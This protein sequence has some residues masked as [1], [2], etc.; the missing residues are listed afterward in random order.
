MAN[1]KIMGH[2]RWGSTFVCK[3]MKDF[4][5]AFRKAEREFYD[6][7]FYHDHYRWFPDREIPGICSSE[8]EAHDVLYEHIWSKDGD[9]SFYVRFRQKQSAK[10]I[11]LESRILKAKKSLDEYQEKHSIHNRKSK[12]TCCG[13]CKTRVVISKVRGEFCPYCG[14]DFQPNIASEISRRRIAICV[15]EKEYEKEKKKVDNG[16]VRCLSK[17]DVIYF[18]YCV[19]LDY[20]F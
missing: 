5:E 9:Y 11:S 2:E 4:D 20:H 13:H 18:L 7:D 10:M 17:N 16:E 14:F 19:G 6:E 15:L 3:T 8:K 12:T 1:G